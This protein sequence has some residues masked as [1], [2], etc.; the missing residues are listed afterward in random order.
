MKKMTNKKG[1]TLVELVIVLA[2]LAILAAIAIPAASAIMGDA[3][4]RADSSST[5]MYCNAIQMSYA[6][7]S[8]YPSSRAAVLT[9][10]KTYTNSATTGTGASEVISNPKQSGNEFYYIVATNKV[11]CQSS[12]PSGTVGT[13]FYQLSD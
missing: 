5:E 10:I 12:V 13:E 2:V 1:F 4:K 7:N 3:N 6:A 9:A 11:V 8:Q